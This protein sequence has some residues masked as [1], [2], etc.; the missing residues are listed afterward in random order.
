MQT[1]WV[2][3]YADRLGMRLC[4]Q[5]GY[6]TMQTDWVWDCEWVGAP[7]CCPGHSLNPKSL[8]CP[9][10]LN[11][12]WS[13]HREVCIGYRTETV[14]ALCTSYEWQSNQGHKQ[15]CLCKVCMVINCTTYMWHQCNIWGS[16][17]QK[18]KT[19]LTAFLNC[20]NYLQH[21]TSSARA[22]LIY[23]CVRHSYIHKAHVQPILS[24]TTLQTRWFGQNTRLKFLKRLH[25]TVKCSWIDT[26]GFPSC[27]ALMPCQSLNHLQYES[28]FPLLLQ[29]LESWLGASE[30]TRFNE[31]TP[32]KH[33]VT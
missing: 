23:R 1:D 28:T 14:L 9:W 5:T 17:V 8:N 32:W 11:L 20:I 3:D 10:I 31:S 6:G 13:T 27:L 12:K 16:P 30:E 15:A 18:S 26:V 22:R 24:D 4:R 21:H 7:V 29:A 2:W 25:G 19:F 33:Q